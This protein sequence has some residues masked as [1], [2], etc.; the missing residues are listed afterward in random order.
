[1][2]QLALRLIMSR[3]LGPLALKLVMTRD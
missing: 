1:M 2:A 3:D